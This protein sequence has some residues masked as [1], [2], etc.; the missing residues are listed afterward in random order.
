LLKGGGEGKKDTNRKKEKATDTWIKSNRS[1]LS[2]CSVYINL[3]FTLHCDIYNIYFVESNK[4]Q[5]LVI[6]YLNI[7][8]NWT[9]G[10]FFLIQIR[11]S[12][13]QITV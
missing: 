8:K 13:T 11:I 9:F 6:V 12:A 4:I 5:V 2:I 7:S 1:S 10:T 3:I